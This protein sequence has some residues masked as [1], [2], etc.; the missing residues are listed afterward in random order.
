MPAPLRVGDPAPDLTLPDA[1][2]QPVRLADFLGRPLVIFFYPADFTPG[3]TAEACSFRDREADLLA[4]GAAVVGISSDSADSHRRFADR[5]RLSFPLL[6]DPSGTA[7]AAF[8]VPKTL[9]L[10]PGRATYILDASGTIRHI[11][12]SQ[13][14]PG[15]HV[16][17]ALAAL[18]SLPSPN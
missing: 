1:D 8:G 2:G 11:F 15:R 17:E 16:D 9:G 3:C 6:S 4:A 14:R 5:H 18:R 13:F 10:I 12:N 7:R